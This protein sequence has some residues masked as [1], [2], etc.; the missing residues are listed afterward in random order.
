MPLSEYQVFTRKVQ[1]IAKREGYQTEE[2]D[3]KVLRELW[4]T[5]VEWARKNP[6]EVA[7]E[8]TET[9]RLKAA[10]QQAI[11]E[12]SDDLAN[13]AADTLWRALNPGKSPIGPNCP[14]CDA[15]TYGEGKCVCGWKSS[16]DEEANGPKT[17]PVDSI[18]SAEPDYGSASPG[19]RAG[20]DAADKF[21]NSCE[22]QTM[23]SNR[24]Y[25]ALTTTA[26]C[27]GWDAA[28]KS[29]DGGQ[30]DERS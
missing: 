13:D 20:F 22:A 10:I 24:A 5:A 21:W 30:K 27:S 4:D 3:Y 29:G 8:V 11:D 6:A 23:L 18:R 1:E 7:A 19:R 9:A 14:K 17:S 26:F 2:E 28:L 25:E 15:Y 16:D 12:L